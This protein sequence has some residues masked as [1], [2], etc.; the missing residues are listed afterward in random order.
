MT[1]TNTN[2]KID[3]AQIQKKIQEILDKVNDQSK[4][5]AVGSAYIA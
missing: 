4:W 3:T 2:T 5:T 1:K